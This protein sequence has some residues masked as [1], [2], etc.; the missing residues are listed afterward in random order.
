MLD[1]QFS[2]MFLLEY[3]IKQVD[4]AD[5]VRCKFATYFLQF[6]FKQIK[7]L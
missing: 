1:Y 6:A 3:Q 2:L 7:M 5:L 4:F